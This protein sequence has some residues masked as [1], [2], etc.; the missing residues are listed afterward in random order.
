MHCNDGMTQQQQQYGGGNGEI[1]VSSRE[2][3]RIG[4]S[5]AYHGGFNDETRDRG[6]TY[7]NLP[8]YNKQ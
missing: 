8:V 3:P 4:E 6:K 2:V 5:E 1:N 7:E